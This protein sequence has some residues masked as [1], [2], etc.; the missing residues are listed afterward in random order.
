MQIFEMNVTH[1]VNSESS[2]ISWTIRGRSSSSNLTEPPLVFA[3]ICPQNITI[4]T[5]CGCRLGSTCWL[6]L[7]LSSPSQ[8]W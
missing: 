5:Y 6:N 4:L 2:V 8:S 1:K 7:L 3:H